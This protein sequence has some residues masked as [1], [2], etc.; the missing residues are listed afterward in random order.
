MPTDGA[1]K[2]RPHQPVCSAKLL[3][4]QTNEALLDRFQSGGRREHAVCSWEQ[5]AT[6]GKMERDV[7]CCS[8]SSV[9]GL[10]LILS[11]HRGQCTA[12]HC[13]TSQTAL[14]LQT[15]TMRAAALSGAV[16]DRCG[17]TSATSAR[18]RQVR[19]AVMRGRSLTATESDLTDVFPRSRWILTGMI[20]G[21]GG[22]ALRFLIIWARPY[23]PCPPGSG[24]KCRRNRTMSNTAP[25]S[26]QPAGWAGSTK[27]REGSLRRGSRLV[28]NSS[29]PL[30][31]KR[32]A[33]RGS[34]AWR[35]GAPAAELLVVPPPWPRHRSRRWALPMRPLRR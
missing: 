33:K 29:T 28:E 14:P 9:F 23:S 3:P 35:S 12:E 18:D 19:Q 24:S 1:G 7:A 26:A 2:T 31:S 25:P 16:D 4:E 8:A 30:V 11:S 13:V 21:T 22:I 34:A 32:D 6:I 15:K 17:G 5:K 10:F 20:G 27:P